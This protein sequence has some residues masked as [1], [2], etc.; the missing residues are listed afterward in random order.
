MKV[1]NDEA[2]ELIS[3]RIRS[4]ALFFKNGPLCQRFEN[5]AVKLRGPMSERVIA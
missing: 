2:R 1:A 5:N 4:V 3:R